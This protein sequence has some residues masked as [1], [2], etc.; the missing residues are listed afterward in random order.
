MSL[1]GL[2]YQTQFQKGSRKKRRK[3]LFLR[4]KNPSLPLL[5]WNPISDLNV[6]TSSCT[7]SAF[8][9]KALERSRTRTDLPAKRTYTKGML[10]FASFATNFGSNELQV[11]IAPGSIPHQ[12]G[13]SIAYVCVLHR[14]NQM[15]H[16]S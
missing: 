16:N 2:T 1:I 7:S 15:I 9:C 4:T 12:D 3:T 14:N 11:E 10:H 6:S 5:D 8:Q 13:D